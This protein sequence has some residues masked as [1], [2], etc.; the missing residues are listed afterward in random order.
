[1]TREILFYWLATSFYGLA[2]IIA[3]TGFVFKKEKLL[4]MALGLGAAGLL[5]HA[6]AI[7]LRW[8]RVGHG[9]YINMYEVMSSDAWVAMFFYLVIQRRLRFLRNAA[10]LVMPLV[11]LSMGFGIMSSMKDLPLPPSLRSYWLVL[12]VIFAKLTTASLLVGSGSAVLY[13]YK[14][15]RPESAFSSRMPSLHRLDYA[16]YRFN[17]LGFAFLTVM[18]VAGSIWANGAWGRY[19]AFDPVETWSL[20]TWLSYGLFLHL[21]LNRNWAGKKSALLTLVIFVGSIL[22]FFFIPY[23]LKTVHSEYLVR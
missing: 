22:A 8:A 16:V 10:V 2:A 13:L 14:K 3:I 19:W 20:L 5:P 18:I 6:A 12:H 21:R 4:N 17:A 11:F 9:P 15:A 7:L 23:L 1:M